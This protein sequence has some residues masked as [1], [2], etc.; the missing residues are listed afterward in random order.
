MKTY[1]CEP[2]LTDTQVFQFCQQGFPIRVI[3]NI[4]QYLR[5]LAT[6]RAEVVDTYNRYL[7]AAKSDCDNPLIRTMPEIDKLRGADPVD[8]DIKKGVGNH[9]RLGKMREVAMATQQLQTV[10]EGGTQ[11]RTDEAKREVTAVTTLL[12]NLGEQIREVSDNDDAEV[13]QQSVPNLIGE[14]N[15]YLATVLEVVN[16]LTQQ[17]ALLTPLQPSFD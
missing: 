15:R 9:P 13:R 4:K 11:M 6:F 10:L 17:C 2:T 7:A 8:Y 16:H 1:D 12:D 5:P 3:L 14:Y